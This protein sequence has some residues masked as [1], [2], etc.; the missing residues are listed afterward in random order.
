VVKINKIF[1]SAFPEGGRLSSSRCFAAEGKGEAGMY[2][3]E[4]MKSPAASIRPAF[5]TVG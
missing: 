3:G 2:G 4:R 1:F 5:T